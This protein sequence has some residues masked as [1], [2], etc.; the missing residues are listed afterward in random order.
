MADIPGFTGLR[1]LPLVRGSLPRGPYYRPSVGFVG[2]KAMPFVRSLVNRARYVPSEFGLGRIANTVKKKGDPVNIPL[3]RKVR[4]IRE[5]D[6]KVV[7]ETISDP[8]TGAYA[9]EA[10]VMEERYTVIAYDYEHGYR[11]AVADNIAPVRA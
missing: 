6:G 11:A 5:R 8:I 9:F 4:C 2:S 3:R 1:A 7:A 10:L